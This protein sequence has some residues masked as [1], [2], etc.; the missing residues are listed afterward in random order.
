MKK[1][2]RNADEL[3]HVWANKLQAEGR[4]ASV[5]FEGDTYYSYGYHYAIGRHLPDGSVAINLSSSSATTNK[6]VRQAKFAVRPRK[7]LEV[8]N[9]GG[10]PDHARTD[11]HVKSLLEDAAAA[12]PNGN[13]PRLLAQAQKVADDYNAFC[14]ALGLAGNP[15]FPPITAAVNDEELARLRKAHRE[16]L[17]EERA[18]EKERARVRLLKD[19]E[20]IAEWRAG[21]S[22]GLGWAVGTLLRVNPSKPFIDTSRG[23]HIPVEDARKLWPLIQRA[24]KGGRDYEVGM[25]VG[26]Y[27]LTKIR[28]D[29]SI[30]VNCHDIPYDEIHG[31]AVALGLASST[32]EETA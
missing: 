19:A 16:Y 28:R 6:H 5:F 29:G 31:I 30:V 26:D 18:R 27:R 10:E 14:A 17:A 11:R 24:M 22:H 4:C 12:K 21:G 13:R 20:R 8:F 9:P 32:V 2:F 25:P 3:S 23:A 1:V 7:V 15:N